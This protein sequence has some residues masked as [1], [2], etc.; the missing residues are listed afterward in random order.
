MCLFLI[1]KLPYKKKK[2]HE[3]IQL[4]LIKFLLNL[5]VIPLCG[6]MAIKF[7][8]VKRQAYDGLFA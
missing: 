4:A 7:G 5:V 2:Q 8:C 3:Q 6:N 1:N